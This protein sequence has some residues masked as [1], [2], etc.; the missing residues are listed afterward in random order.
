MPSCAP[1]RAAVGPSSGR[2][3]SGLFV[4]VFAWKHSRGLSRLTAKRRTQPARA[5]LFSPLAA[6]RAH[7]P[8]LSR[9]A[10]TKSAAEI[11]DPTGNQMRV[12]A[13]VLSEPPRQERE[14]KND[15]K[16]PVHGL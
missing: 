7:S 5:A 1:H 9:P 10:Q 4:A 13:V 2:R 15:A 14:Q 16:S 6:V 11:T 3:R 8:A 12:V